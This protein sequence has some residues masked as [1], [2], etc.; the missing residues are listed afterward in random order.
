M[1]V[2]EEVKEGRLDREG[3]MEG[4]KQDQDGVKGRLVEGKKKKGKRR[5]KGGRRKEQGRCGGER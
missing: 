5:E 1:K 4:R 2:W 3:K